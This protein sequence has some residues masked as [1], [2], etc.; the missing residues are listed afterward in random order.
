MQKEET[1]T[2]TSAD[3]KTGTP[4]TTAAPERSIFDEDDDD[5]LEAGGFDSPSPPS[6]PHSPGRQALSQAIQ[7]TKDSSKKID[8][9]AE[10]DPEPESATAEVGKGATSTTSFAD[11]QQMK[12]SRT[13]AVSARD[14]AIGRSD[15]V[16]SGTPRRRSS[17][18]R[19]AA[20]DAS[21]TSGTGPRG[22]S[23]RRGRGRDEASQRDGARQKN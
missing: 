8:E 16:G 9:G 21:R 11:F 13:K 6:S 14:R 15:S 12:K 1:S 17:Q 5:W 23:T 19:S 2:A 20:A 7:Q 4:A 18:R 10:P 22:N 3:T